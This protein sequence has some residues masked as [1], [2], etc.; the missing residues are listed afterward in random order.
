MGVSQVIIIASRAWARVSSLKAAGDLFR[1]A[2]EIL[3]VFKDGKLSRSIL[4]LGAIAGG[5]T[6]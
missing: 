3:I 2:N 5:I 1:L 6:V 4:G